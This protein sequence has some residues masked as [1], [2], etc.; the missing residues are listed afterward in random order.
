MLQS[1]KTGQCAGR[2]KILNPISLIFYNATSEQVYRLPNTTHLYKV[3]HDVFPQLWL[4]VL[5]IRKNNILSRSIFLATC[6]QW[7]HNIFTLL[8][9]SLY[10]HIFIWML[11][12]SFAFD[13]GSVC[14]YPNHLWMIWKTRD[15]TCFKSLVMM[16][17][18]FVD[19][20]EL[21]HGQHW[22]FSVVNTEIE[23]FSAHL[24]IFH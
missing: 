18:R 22:F 1:A 2:L 10:L 3:F 6:N 13:Q 20:P 24:K 11:T 23:Q 14:S 19:L 17:D 4:K 7:N 8:T 21:Y 12:R 5:L 9:F 15:I 16:L